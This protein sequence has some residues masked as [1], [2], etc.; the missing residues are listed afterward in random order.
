ME[1]IKEADYMHAKGVCKE[2]ETKNLSEYHALYVK[3][4]TLLLAEVFKNVRKMDLKFII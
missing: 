4:Y 1:Y 3:S 2:Y